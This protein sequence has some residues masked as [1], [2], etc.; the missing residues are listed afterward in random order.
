LARRSAAEQYVEALNAERVAAG[1]STYG[2]AATVV[3]THTN[4][5][6]SVQRQWCSAPNGP[7]HLRL[8]FT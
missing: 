3:A 6:M 5:V 7:V 2:A 8:D 1:E 4:A